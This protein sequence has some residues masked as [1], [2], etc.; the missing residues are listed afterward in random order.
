MKRW[1]PLFF[2]L[3]F[4]IIL[5]RA[6]FLHPALIPSPL[7]NKPAPHFVLPTLFS[8]EQITSHHDFYGKVTVVNVWAT[9]CYACN[10]EHDFLM[11]I[12][13]QGYL[14]YGLNYKDNKE[15]AKRWLAQKGNPYHTIAVDATGRVGI[16]WGVYGTPESFIIDKKGLIRY[17]LIGPITLQ[18]WQEVLL[19]IIQKLAQEN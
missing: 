1:L 9:W 15:A 19:P 13:K 10:L 3:M 16:D 2:V 4:F 6:L 12:A 7:I 8:P 17:K 11:A 18:N 5:G 14:I